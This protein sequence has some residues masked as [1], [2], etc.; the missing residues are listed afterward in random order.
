VERKQIEA[1]AYRKAY[2]DLYEKLLKKAGDLDEGVL[3]RALKEIKKDDPNDSIIRIGVN[4]SKSVGERN[5]GKATQRIEGRVDHSVSILDELARSGEL[6]VIDAVV[7]REE[8]E[9]GDP[10]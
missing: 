8:L 10:G 7:V 1:D 4:V 9:A 2:K 5:M 6:D 3:D